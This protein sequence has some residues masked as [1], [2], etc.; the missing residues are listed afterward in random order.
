MGD[1]AVAGSAAIS[2]DLPGSFVHTYGKL[3]SHRRLIEPT[4]IAVLLLLR[5]LFLRLLLIRLLISPSHCPLPLLRALLVALFSAASSYRCRRTLYSLDKASRSGPSS[6]RYS[7][8]H[9]RTYRTFSLAC[10]RALLYR[11]HRSP[12]FDDLVLPLHA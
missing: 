1:K 3:Y 11:H 9:R 6:T 4:R 10:Q 5:L 7:A 8:D 2:W 12:S